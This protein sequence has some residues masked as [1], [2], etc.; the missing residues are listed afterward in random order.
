MMII[1]YEDLKTAVGGSTRQQVTANLRQM[2]I[3]FILRPD[4][5]P[6][7]TTDAFNEAMSIKRKMPNFEQDNTVQQG[8]EV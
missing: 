4:G 5:K 3:R 2:R 7:S 1:S 6:I 8:I